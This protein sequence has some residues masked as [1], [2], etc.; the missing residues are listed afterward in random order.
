M[1]TCLTLGSCR[2]NSFKIQVFDWDVLGSFELFIWRACYNKTNNEINCSR[3]FIFRS[4]K[5]WFTYF[6]SV[7]F[8]LHCPQQPRFAKCILQHVNE[9]SFFLCF[10]RR[11][12]TLDVVMNICPSTKDGT[13]HAGRMTAPNQIRHSWAGGDQETCPV[14]SKMTGRDRQWLLCSGKRT[15]LHWTVDRES[16]ASQ[17]YPGPEGDQETCPV[18]SEITKMDRWWVSGQGTK[19]WTVDSG[20]CMDMSVDII[21][22]KGQTWQ[23][24]I[25]VQ[26]PGRSVSRH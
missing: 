20:E 6:Q 7:M 13:V 3:K 26:Y 2:K 10:V 12:T 5:E 21:V 14:V 1:H 11:Y 17:L 18:D 22:F 15:D 24:I 4:W 25:N 16:T 19:H 9:G 8:S 23:R